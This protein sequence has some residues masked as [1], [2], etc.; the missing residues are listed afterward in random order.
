M[1]EEDELTHQ[2]DELLARLQHWQALKTAAGTFAAEETLNLLVH[3]IM[4]NPSGMI[5]TALFGG[6]AALAAG[7]Q[8]PKW[9]RT[10]RESLPHTE[11]LEPLWLL[12]HREPGKRSLLD[13]LLDRPL[14]TD[15]DEQ[16]EEGD[17]EEQG[18]S[19][20]RQQVESGEEWD[21]AWYSDEDEDL[22]GPGIERGKTFFTFSEVLASGFIPSLSA[23]YLGR[24]SDGTPITVPA[25]DLCHVALPGAT[26]HGKS[27]LI[28]LLMAQLCSCGLPVYLL[29]P[30]YTVFDQEHHEDWTPFTPYL[31]S[32]PFA[33]MEMS[34]I[35]TVLEWMTTTL[36]SQRKERV[37]KG[38]RVGKPYFFILDEVPDIVASVAGA[39]KMIGKLLREGRKYGIYL[40]IAS[41]DFSV[42][43]LGMEG[44]GSLRK[45]F[46]TIL[47]VGGDPISVRELLNARNGKVGELLIDENS[48][49]MG[50]I[51]VRYMDKDRERGTVQ[52]VLTP[53]RTPYTDNESLYTLLGPSTFTPDDEGPDDEPRQ[54]HAASQSRAIGNEAPAS[55]YRSINDI[56]IAELTAEQLVA[57]VLQLPMLHPQGDGEV[58]AQESEA[59]S[60]STLRLIRPDESRADTEQE[61]RYARNGTGSD[62]HPFEREP[63]DQ[64]PL[65][66]GRNGVDEAASDAAV[67]AQTNDVPLPAGWDQK[68]LDMLSGFY[69]VF[70]NLDDTLKALQLS[71]SQRNQDVARNELKRQ[72][73]WK[74]AR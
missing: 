36:L 48:L 31:K 68:K 63:E 22:R 13:K 65:R 16:D 56:P 10:V 24:K 43:T 72:G 39:S 74:E 12:T 1:Y 40:I 52:T 27:S 41:Q 23:I 26:G 5:E 33:C 14:P 57:A 18:P 58:E 7:Y 19:H 51:I 28:R 47:Y 25:K 61:I 67:R 45:C 54:R 2:Q 50:S 35:K 37:A 73:L 3:A 29:N 8:A 42:K 20:K 32:D 71:T 55:R 66:Y 62:P 53:A 6:I 38:G 60:P 64:P 46:H 21:E 15:E 59:S 34:A 70:G 9:L 11:E 30:H 4:G 49:G 17:D 44:E 69:A